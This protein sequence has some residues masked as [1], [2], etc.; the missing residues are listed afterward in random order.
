MNADDAELILEILADLAAIEAAD[1]VD[2]QELADDIRELLVD[3]E[4][5]LTAEDAPS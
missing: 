5:Y 1:P 2:G 3:I 4:I